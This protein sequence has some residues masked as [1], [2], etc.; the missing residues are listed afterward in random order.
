ME[1][2]SVRATLNFTSLTYLLMYNHII[3]L[4]GESVV[5]LLTRAVV[6]RYYPGLHSVTKYYVI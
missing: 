4:P 2:V 6:V 5:W 1:K 3:F